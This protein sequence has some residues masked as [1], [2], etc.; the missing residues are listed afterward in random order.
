MLQHPVM[1]TH[2]VKNTQTQCKTSENSGPYSNKALTDRKTPQDIRISSVQ[3]SL[4]M[5]LCHWELPSCCLW[6]HTWVPEPSLKKEIVLTINFTSFLTECIMIL[7][8]TIMTEKNERK[9]QLFSLRMLG[10]VQHLW[11]VILKTEN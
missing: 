10:A 3:I 11:C 2:F 4:S 7:R 8:E 6:L 5:M 1:T 9:M